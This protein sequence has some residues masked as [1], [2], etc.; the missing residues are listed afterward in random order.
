MK[1]QYPSQDRLRELFDYDPE[2]FLVWKYRPEMSKAW[3]SRMANKKAGCEHLHSERLKYSYTERIS[4]KD[5]SGERLIWIIH[6][7]EIDLSNMV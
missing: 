4:G 3:N 1:K 6:H 2:G 7:A 5:Y